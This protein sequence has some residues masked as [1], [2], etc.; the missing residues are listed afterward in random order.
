MAGLAKIWCNKDHLALLEGWSRDG[1]S[2]RDIAA[3]IG[4]GYTT[5]TKWENEHLEIEEALAKGKELIDYKVENALLKAALGYKTKEVKVTVTMRGG[6][7]V[8]KINEKTTKEQ[9]PNVQAC[10]FWLT[11][12][13]PEKWKKDRSKAISFD[14]DEDT[15]IQVTVTKA[16]KQHDDDEVNSSIELRKNKQEGTD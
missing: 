4:I 15:S 6:R 16:G 3:K 13:L 1:W 9:P 2:K 14:E 11:N 7:V 8:E 12:S 10:Q 5:L